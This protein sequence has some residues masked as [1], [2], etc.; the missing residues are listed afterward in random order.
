MHGMMMGDGMSCSEM[1]GHADVKVE[2]TSSGAVIR[3][4]AKNKDQVKHVQHMAQ[5]MKRCMSG[6]P[7]AGSKAK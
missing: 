4:T 7:A 5:M 3:L 6:E 2:N 1:M